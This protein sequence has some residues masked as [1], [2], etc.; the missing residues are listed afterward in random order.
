M[1][2]ISPANEART[3]QRADTSHLVAATNAQS[4]SSYRRAEPPT[5]AILLQRRMQRNLSPQSALVVCTSAEPSA[6]ITN[7]ARGGISVS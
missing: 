3:D 7:D 4:P 6:Y 5:Q 2:T 1:H